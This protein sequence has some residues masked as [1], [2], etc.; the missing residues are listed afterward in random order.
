[1]AA[2]RRHA[3]ALGE[4]PCGDITPTV[5]IV[6]TPVIDTST[7]AI[8]AVADTWDAATHEAEHVLKG[9]R[10]S[11]GEQV[12]STPV[13]PPGAQPKDLLQR[14][15]LNLDGSDL[16]FGFGGNDGD[17]ADY[18]GTVVAAP[19]DGSRP[20]FWQVRSHCRPHRA[21]RVGAERA[22]RGQRRERVCTTAT[23]STGRARSRNL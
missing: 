5:G 21:G 16:I 22:R 15:A 7:D 6:G 4:L 17:C 19:L 12:L 11:N 18:R 13:E 23:R 2:E 14:T 1:M 20:R 10:L 9:Y 3:G 8:Y